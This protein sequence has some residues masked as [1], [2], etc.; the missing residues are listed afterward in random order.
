MPSPTTTIVG[1]TMNHQHSVQIILAP[2]PTGT[3]DTLTPDL[4]TEH[5]FDSAGLHLGGVYPPLVVDNVLTSA[6]ARCVSTRP[7]QLLIHGPACDAP[8]Q[9]IGLVWMMPAD[10]DAF[11]AAMQVAP[12]LVYALD[13]GWSVQV[14]AASEAAIAEAWMVMSAMTGGGHA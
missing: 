5:L 14:H 2:S 10:R 12:W 9:R 13:A 8:R 4:R 11:M 1:S 3:R 7:A 6:H